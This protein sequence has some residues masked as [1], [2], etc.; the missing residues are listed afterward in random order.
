MLD[1]VYMR[2]CESNEYWAKE[3]VGSKGDIYLVKFERVFDGHVEY[4]Y[5]CTCPSF[6]YGNKKGKYCK[7]ILS[8][9]P[10]H[11]GW[12][13][14]F[15]DEVMDENDEECKCPKCGGPTVV[16]RVGV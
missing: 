10:E 4:D 13:E 15:S 6:K 11:C 16:I 12:H 8:A 5:T 7:H 9:K 3:V 14:Q 2:M 1:I